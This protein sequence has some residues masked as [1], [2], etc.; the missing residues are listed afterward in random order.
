M[1]WIELLVLV[2]LRLGTKASGT[3][4]GGTAARPLWADRWGCVVSSGA[5]SLL[6]QVSCVQAD[7]ERRIGENGLG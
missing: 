6:P 4:R 2:L 7:R 3:F 5:F 1:S